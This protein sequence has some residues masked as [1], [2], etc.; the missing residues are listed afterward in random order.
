M[1]IVSN[2]IMLL[3]SIVL[4]RVSGKKVS[5]LIEFLVRFI[6]IIQLKAILFSQKPCSIPIDHCINQNLKKDFGPWSFGV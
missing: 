6:L 3:L 1:N 2:F 5:L 4:Y